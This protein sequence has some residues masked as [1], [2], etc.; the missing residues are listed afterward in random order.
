MAAGASAVFTVSLSGTS[1][2]RYQWSYDKVDLPY[3]TNASLVFSPARQT[4]AGSYAVVVTNLAGAVTSQIAQ[5]SVAEGRF[6]T[7]AQGARLPYRLFFPPKYDPGTNY[8]LVLF[9]HGRG[10]E[11]T[12][13]Y[14]QLTDN[15]QVL[16]PDGFQSSQEPLLL[17]GAA[18]ST[19][20]N[21]L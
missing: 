2:F 7:N 9:W 13:N 1:P 4:N 5:L 21:R 19:R 20:Q 17:F 18:D 10:A 14:N 6:F 12:D 11:G 15:G 8:P 3:G 16:L